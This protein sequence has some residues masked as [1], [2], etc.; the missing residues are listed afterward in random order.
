VGILDRNGGFWE[1]EFVYL[2]DRAK[3]AAA[4]VDCR[5]LW[6]GDFSFTDRYK[7]NEV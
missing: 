4:V 2:D 1:I 5:C 6:D 3:G 7:C